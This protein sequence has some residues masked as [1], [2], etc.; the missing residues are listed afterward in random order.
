MG[1]DPNHLLTG[2]IGQVVYFFF[3]GGEMIIFFSEWL[4]DGVTR[5]K[6]EAN[7]GCIHHLRIFWGCWT[8]ITFHPTKRPKLVELFGFHQKARW[9][10]CRSHGFIRISLENVTKTAKGLAED[11]GDGWKS[12]LVLLDM[13][14]LADRRPKIRLQSC[15]RSHLKR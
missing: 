14:F 5:L 7:V 2:M 15:T 10:L 4:N 8:M 13:S 11:W 6:G 12:V 9:N 1:G 3:G